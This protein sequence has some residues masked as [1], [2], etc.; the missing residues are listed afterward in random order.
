VILL[1]QNIEGVDV[2]LFA[3]YVQEFGSYP[4]Q[5]SVYLSYLDSVKYF[6]PE[7][8]TTSGEALLYVQEFGSE[9]GYPNQHIEDKQDKTEFNQDGINATKKVIEPKAD[10]E[11]ETKSPNPTVNIVSLTDF[12]PSNE[13]TEHITSL[14]KQFNQRNPYYYYRKEDDTQQ[15]FFCTKCYKTAQGGSGLNVINA[16]VGSIKICALRN[17]KRNLDCSAEY[18][19]SVCCLKETKNRMLAK[20]SYYEWRSSSYLRL[21]RDIGTLLIISVANYLLSVLTLKK[22]RRTINYGTGLYHSMLRKAAEE[23]IVVGLTNIYDHFFVPT[24]NCDSKVT[25]ARLPYF[26][27]DYWSGAAIPF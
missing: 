6:R 4:N 11:K 17:Y 14:T 19:C 26:D 13:I 9:C 5:R 2:C 15:Q 21:P 22:L 27:G 10:Q 23:N 7:R 18:T 12:F 20:K 8:V 1:F 16:K 3:M 25:A 24:G